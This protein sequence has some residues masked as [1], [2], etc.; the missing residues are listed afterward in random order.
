MPSITRFEKS[1]AE[2]VGKAGLIGTNITVAISGGP[3][4]TAMLLALSRTQLETGISIK[5]AHLDHGIRG[6]ESQAD[7]EYVKNLCKSISVDCFFGAVDVPSLSKVLRIS[8][9]DAA[10]LGVGPG[11]RVRITT[12][13]G[14]AEAPVEV[15]DTLRSGHVTLPNGLGLS[16]PDENG[17][18]VVHGVAPNEL[19]SSEDRDWLAG[20]PWHK[21]VRAR[22]EALGSGSS[23]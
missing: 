6:E 5:G 13:R 16:Y 10:E 12:K 17:K 8:L 18:R 4:S 22:I 15:T 1:V 14:S 7:A 9:E 11:D 19:T 3:D 20:T 21:H 23:G 2:A